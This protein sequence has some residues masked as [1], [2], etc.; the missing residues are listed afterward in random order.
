MVFHFNFETR[1]DEM[2]T[3][4]CAHNAGIWSIAFGYIE[5]RVANGRID[6][7][8][9][10]QTRI[11]SLMHIKCKVIACHKKSQKGRSSMIVVNGR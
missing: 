7:C 6:R 11:K 4:T 2:Q 3:E 9:D 1:D 5:K 8:T 10:L